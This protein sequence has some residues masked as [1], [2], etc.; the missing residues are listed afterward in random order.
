MA[1]AGE[2]AKCSKCPWGFPNNP[3]SIEEHFGYKAPDTPYKLCKRCRAQMVVW[4]KKS[5]ERNRDAKLAYIKDYRERHPEKS[6]AYYDKNKEHIR[7]YCNA[8]N[9]AH[10]EQINEKTR[11]KIECELCGREVCRDTLKRHQGTR[12]CEK[13][14]PAP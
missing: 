14:R 2:V 5:Y 4:N 10:R 6:K 11:T 1:G 3:V 8:Y 13:N 12:I 7:A 9:A